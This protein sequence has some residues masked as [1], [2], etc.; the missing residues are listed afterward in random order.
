[1]NRAATIEGTPVRMST[2][3]LTTLANFLPR[4][5]STR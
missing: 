2:M 1:M 5:Y 3:K 4:A